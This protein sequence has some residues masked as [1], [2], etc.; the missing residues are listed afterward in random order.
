MSYC[1]ICHYDWPEENNL[2]LLCSNPNCL[3]LEYH[4]F[5]LEENSQKIPEVDR[6]WYCPTCHLYNKTIKLIEYFK[7]FKSFNVKKKC[8]IKFSQYIENNSENN[9]S[10]LIG[11]VI[12]LYI[13]E[14]NTGN[15]LNLYISFILLLYSSLSYL[16]LFDLFIIIIICIFY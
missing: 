7:L 9:K 15:Q 1:T 10:N 4:L 6:D 13:P 16:I 3:P 14:I 11:C 2:T 5:C 8:N 12:K